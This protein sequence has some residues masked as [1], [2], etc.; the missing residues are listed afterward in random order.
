MINWKK[1]STIALVLNLLIGCSSD[2]D[3][4]VND[5]DDIPGLLTHYHVPGVSIAI[6]KDFKI[7]QLLVYGERSQVT[8][9]PVTEDTLFQAA[10]ISK[11]VAALA[12]MKMSQDG[13][14]NLDED[15]NDI[16]TSWDVEENGFTVDQKVTLR[17]ILG[18]TAGI[19]VHGFQG[20]SK[21]DQIPSLIE[22]LNGQA[23]ANSSAIVVDNKPGSGFSY[24]GGGY[25]I[26][27][28]ALIDVT[29]QTFEDLMSEAV[30][31]PL[32]MTSSSFGQL[33]SEDRVA[34]ASAGHDANGHNIF[35]DYNFYPELAAAGLWTTPRDL[36]RLLIEL[37]LSLLNQSNTLLASEVVEEMIVPIEGPIFGSGNTYYGLG[38]M[39]W[40][41]GDEKYFG[42]GGTNKGF[43]SQMMAHNRLGM[44]YVVMTNGDNGE[45]V[46][47]KIG[48]LIKMSEKWPD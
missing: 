20:Y 45:S 43:Q 47:K 7:D 26:A 9:A 48:S 38:F 12:A 18:H 34:S 3:Y 17:R 33:L 8:L 22:M 15:I 41:E 19:T 40:K 23:T 44:G 35:A 30:L 28:Q 14:V 6:I 21:N 29:Q 27:Q 42:H 16:L 25:L 39:V 1:Y 31:E 4:V 13:M 11:S 36:A 46:L 5:F 32:A 37:Q 24:S 10:S 2:T